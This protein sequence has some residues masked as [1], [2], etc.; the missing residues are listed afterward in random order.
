[1]KRALKFILSLA[2]TLACTWW[3]FHPKGNVCLD[4]AQPAIVHAPCETDAQC[5]AGTCQP[6]TWA[7]ERDEQWES[8]KGANYYWLIPYFGILLFIH[9]SRTLRWG[10]WLS[11]IEKVP[12]RKLNDASAIGFMMLII[13]PLR[14]GEFARPYLIA[15]RSKI[16]RSAAMTTVV[17][18]RIVDAIVI[19]TLLRVL[20][21]FV[22]NETPEVAYVKW[23]AN[24]MY[25]IFGGGLVFLLF[26]LWQRERA[27]RLVRVTAGRV[28]PGVAHK[29]ADIVDSFVGAMKKLPGPGGL[30]GFA[31]FTLGY[32]SVN[33]LGM[34]VLARA[35]N[36][37]LNIFQ[38]YVV[39]AVL[40]VGLM[41]PAAPGM[42]GTF[43]A[44]VK[45][46]LGLFLPAAVVSGRGLAYANVMWLCQTLQQIGIGFLFMSLSHVSFQDVTKNLGEGGDEKKDEKDK[47]DPPPERARA[48]VVP[49]L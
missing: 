37:G 48:P 35:F 5:T 22:P 8:L 21:F 6:R 28:A 18:E 1:L 16:G 39:L 27:V 47:D 43:Q 31:V 46:G 17:L 30:V 34:W 44:A 45:V 49:M 25:A 24:L 38:G 7:M 26:A 10:Y 2:V 42:V 20:L 12:F 36:V 19:A 32:W 33:G 29:V 14:L 23:G 3:A 13:L 11:G 4:S 9:L 41:I 40:V 15:S